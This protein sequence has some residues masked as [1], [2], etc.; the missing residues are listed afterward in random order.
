MK[1]VFQTNKSFDE[2]KNVVLKFIKEYLENENHQVKFYK[3]PLGFF[4]TRIIQEKDV[5]IRLHIWT[6]NYQI[7][8]D[9]FIHDHY[10][11]LKSW[12]LCGEIEDF[13]Y[14]LKKSEDNSSLAKYV[15]SYSESENYRYLKLTNEY[16]T[17][18]SKTSKIITSGNL[19]SID[20]SKFHSNKIHFKNS[21][22]TST[23]VYTF[24]PNKNHEPV[25]LGLKRIERIVEEAP[26]L[27]PHEDM[28]SILNQ[29]LNEIEKS[30][31]S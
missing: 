2:V 15:G 14:K 29:L 31:Y 23:L 22:I 16:Y 30:N 27:I 6:K 17:I 18:I 19:Y 10:Y 7:K 28:K 4:Y 20:K 12:V 5:Q 3:H 21:N 25:V 26:I 1:H 8:E 9:L 11:D 24:N 13:T